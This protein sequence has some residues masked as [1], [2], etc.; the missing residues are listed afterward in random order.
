[1]VHSILAAIDLNADALAVRDS[2][3]TLAR[4]FDATREEIEAIIVVVATALQHPV[5]RRAAAH[6]TEK[7]KLR[8][9]TPVLLRLADGSLAEGVVDLAFRDREGTFD[10][11]TVIDF[12]TNKEFSGSSAH[13]IEQV[14][15]YSQAIQD[16]TGLP[17]RGV[18]LVL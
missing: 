1:M 18:L 15:L 6:T 3:A 5:L 13:Y 17:A 9:E 14:S 11:W 4:M 8:R 12:K 10:G 2:A 7:G 16:A